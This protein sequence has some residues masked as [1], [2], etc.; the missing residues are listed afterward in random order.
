MSFQPV[1]ACRGHGKIHGVCHKWRDASGS[2]HIE[3]VIALSQLGTLA[4]SII[5][6]RTDF[7]GSMIDGRTVME[8]PRKSRSAGKIEQLWTYLE[9]RLERENVAPEVADVHLLPPPA[10]TY[11]IRSVV[12]EVLT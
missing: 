2:Y 3:A 7:A 10:Q 11:G 9:G 1:R 6:Q 4:P 12:G 8:L 5:H